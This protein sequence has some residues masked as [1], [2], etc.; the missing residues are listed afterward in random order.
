MPGHQNKLSR[1]WQELKRRRVINVVTVYASAAFVIIELIGNLTEPLNLPASL[2]T[3]VI[4]VLAIGFP[5]AIVLS[6]LYDLTSG[7]FERTRPLEDV[8]E[9]GKAR[10]PNAWKI[11]TYVSFV[12]IIGLAALNIVSRGNIIKPGM[13]QSVV[14]LPFN[15]YTDDDQLQSL[16]AGMH[17]C[18]I[19]DIG[20]LSGWR[21]INSTTSNV[22]K[23]ASMSVQK[24]ATELNV[25]AAIE[26]SVLGVSDTIILQVSLINAFP[27]E[28]T[29]WN[30]EYKEEKS[31]MLNLY[32]RITK[33]IADEMKVPITDT[34]ELILEK[35][36]TVDPE[37][38]FAYMKGQ[39]HWE[40]LGK[41]DLDSALQ[42]FQLAIDEDPDWADPYAGMAL[43]WDCLGGFG[44]APYA[45]SIEK[46][47]KYLDKALELDPNSAN[48]HYV[49][50]LLLVW[51]G[52]DWEN[53]EKEFLKTLELQPNHAL[54]RIYYAHLLM[55][56]KRFDDARYQADLALQLD[57]M[58]PLVLG[59]YA[60]VM[61]FTGNQQAALV[62]AEKAVSIDP[63]NNFA[64]GILT[65]FYLLTGDTLKWYEL[66]R[67]DW[68][69]TDEEYLDSL[70]TIFQEGGYQAVIREAIRINEEAFKR[71]NPINL[72]DQAFNYLEIGNYERA[73]DFYE[74]AYEQ[75]WGLLS[76]IGLDVIYYPGLKNNSRYIALLKKM[77]LP[78]PE[79]D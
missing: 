33:Q 79:S 50:A 3:I 41:E 75:G 38:L 73:M 54:C 29:I 63:D 52:G 21:V 16:V 48:S 65:G 28:E 49:K 68:Y 14:V 8:P 59:L 37:A 45:E 32:N 7:T 6:W 10:V 11:A 17:A 53:G 4:I 70:D 1:F 25:D 18:L 13:I 22:Y 46:A 31:Q 42:Y 9:E 20:R 2:S 39:F 40:R 34:E 67:K 23:D 43:T 24:I 66:T 72:K 71:G 44:H 58:Q 61:G 30:S 64:I 60:A 74:I 36:R 5:L 77:N 27:E 12:V 62:Q 47:N 26:A 76:Y 35:S 56:L 69:L 19:T 57:P 51:P 55:I 15:N 78:L